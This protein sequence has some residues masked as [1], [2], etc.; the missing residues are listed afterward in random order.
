MAVSVSLLLL[1]KKKKKGN[2]MTLT[3]PTMFFI[4]CMDLCCQNKCE[5]NVPLK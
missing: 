1:K 2:Y 5:S 3:L 4:S